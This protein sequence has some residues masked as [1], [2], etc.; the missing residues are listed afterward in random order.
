MS[1]KKDRDEK[2]LSFC[3]V[4]ATTG[5]PYKFVFYGR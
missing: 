5:R 4:G 2:S 3:N 1:V